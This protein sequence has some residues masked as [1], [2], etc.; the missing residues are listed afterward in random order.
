MNKAT[1]MSTA[2]RVLEL[3]VRNKIK[4][5]GIPAFKEAAAAIANELIPEPSPEPTFSDVLV[6][7]TI[8]IGAQLATEAITRTRTSPTKRRAKSA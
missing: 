7:E 5:E 3:A 6:K 4:L 8:E 2:D 1:R